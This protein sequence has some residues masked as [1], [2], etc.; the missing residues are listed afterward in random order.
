MQ[1]DS[2]TFR[3]GEAGRFQAIGIRGKEGG[4]RGVSTL[5]CLASWSKGKR[6]Y[7]CEELFSFKGQKLFQTGPSERTLTGGLRGF[8]ADTA[9]ALLRSSV[10]TSMPR[11]HLLQTPGT[12]P[13]GFV[14]CPGKQEVPGN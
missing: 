13:E 5:P 12:Q 3:D 11:D 9:G 8:A 6:G 1:D 2:K 14:L 4:W 10:P 7:L